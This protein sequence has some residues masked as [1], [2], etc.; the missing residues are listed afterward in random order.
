[1]EDSVDGIGE[2]A[3]W[4]RSFGQGAEVLEPLELLEA[5]IADLEQMLQN[6]GG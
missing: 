3:V 5:V 4:V 1:M 2:M 6:Y